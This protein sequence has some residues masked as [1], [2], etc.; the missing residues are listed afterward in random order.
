MVRPLFILV[1]LIALPGIARADQDDVPVSF[2]SAD[3]LFTEDTDT[4]WLTAT[5]TSVDLGFYALRDEHHSWHGRLKGD[6]AIAQFGRDTLWRMGL[7]MQTVADHRNEI[8]FRLT[9]LYYDTSL[10]LEHRL[11]SG[12]GYLGYRHRCSHGADAAVPGRILIRSGPELGYQHDMS[13]GALVLSAR[14]F[15]HGTLIGQ[16]SDPK[17]KPRLHWAKVFRLAYRPASVTWFA[18]LGYGTTLVSSG[19]GRTFGFGTPWRDMDFVVLPAAALGVIAHGRAADFTVMLH[20]QR[21]MDSGFGVTGDPSSLANLEL[22][23]GW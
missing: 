12:V 3:H 9:R 18:S 4:T 20:Y 10:L 6:L 15:L 22:G 11:F 2:G 13:W 16:N 23:F 17:F 5:E 7:A 19:K 8:A 1:A 14:A 21:I